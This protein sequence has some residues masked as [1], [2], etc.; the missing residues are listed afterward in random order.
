MNDPL[1]FKLY[2]TLLRND[3]LGVFM[4]LHQQARE[5]KL[6]DHKIFL[7]VCAVLAD[8]VRRASS[9]NTKLKNGIR[10]PRDY[11]N[12][13]TALRSYGHQSGQQYAI[14][15]SQLGGPS[16]R[17]LRYV[18]AYLTSENSVPSCCV[19]TLS[20]VEMSFGVHQIVSRTQSL[21]TKMSRV[22]SGSWIPA[23]SAGPTSSLA[24]Q[25]RSAN[26]SRILTTLAVMY[27]ALYCLSRT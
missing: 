12:F 6:S 11:L 13:M 26:D 5:G 9:S 23:P 18:T 8:Q 10:Y 14:L 24:M 20:L 27:L 15:S 19:L 1:I 16:P 4:Q 2:Q 17:S 25:P 22:S 7:D 21:F 3:S